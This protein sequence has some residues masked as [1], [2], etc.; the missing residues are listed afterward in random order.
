GMH[1]VHELR[2]RMSGGKCSAVRAARAEVGGFCRALGFAEAGTLDSGRCDR[3]D[4]LRNR[5]LRKSFVAMEARRGTARV[6]GTG[7]AGRPGVTS[8]YV[9]IIRQTKARTLS[10]PFICWLILSASA[11]RPQRRASAGSLRMPL[12]LGLRSR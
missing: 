7:T 11:S 9:D 12:R 8:R 4:L 3:A 2:R 10:A 1:R 5:R 6:Y